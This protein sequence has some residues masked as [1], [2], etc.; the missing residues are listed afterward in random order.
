MRRARL[1]ACACVAAA[2]DAW[3]FLGA[4]PRQYVARALAPSEAI[5]VDGDLDEPAWAA[6]LLDKFR[7]D[8]MVPR[9]CTN[10]EAC[11]TA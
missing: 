2:D 5:V 11:S 8:E 9:Q 6:E 1:L 4:Y 7:V 3:K 10:H